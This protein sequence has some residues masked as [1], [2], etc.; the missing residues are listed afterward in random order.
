VAFDG[1]RVT[2]GL[3]IGIIPDKSASRKQSAQAFSTG[4]KGPKHVSSPRATRNA[5]LAVYHSPRRSCI[6]P[7]ALLTGTAFMRMD[8]SPVAEEPIVPLIEGQRSSLFVETS[9]PG[10]SDRP[11]YF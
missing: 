5:P 1:C 7:G 2:G 4:A 8:F 11:R 3:H 9:D 10:G 6:I